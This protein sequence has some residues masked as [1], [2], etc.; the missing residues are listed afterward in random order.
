M[1]KLAI[2]AAVLAGLLTVSIAA[3]RCVSEE[4]YEALS[5]RLADG[6]LALA[7][8]RK[9][10][11]AHA[12][13][14]DDLKAVLRNLQHSCENAGGAAQVRAFA[15]A[16]L[17]RSGPSITAL[18]WPRSTRQTRWQTRCVLLHFV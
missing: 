16:N 6:S 18:P 2:A 7:E 1:S 12:A 17:R 3:A 14:L 4:E 5:D 10:V 11:A 9:E 8:C 13:E 15:A